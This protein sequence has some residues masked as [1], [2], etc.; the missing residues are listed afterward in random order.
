MLVLKIIGTDGI[1]V[2]PFLLIKKSIKRGIDEIQLFYNI[3]LV[4]IYW[5]FR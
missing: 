5:P 3:L 2:S 1:D 4:I